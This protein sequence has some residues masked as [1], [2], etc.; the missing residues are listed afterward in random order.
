MTIKSH[1][2][3]KEILRAL[4]YLLLL[5]FYTTSYIGHIIGIIH[6]I[7]VI[8]NHRKYGVSRLINRLVLFLT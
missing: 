1:K 2:W 6:L 3:I 8:R 5:L 4:L 7:A